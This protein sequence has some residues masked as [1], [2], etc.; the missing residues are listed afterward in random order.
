M[1][2]AMVR[3]N[4][5]DSGHTDYFYGAIGELRGAVD[6]LKNEVNEASKYALDASHGVASLSAQ[7][8][9]ISEQIKAL[10]EREKTGF[11]GT[12]RELILSTWY[13]K[14]IAATIWTALLIFLIVLFSQNFG[15]TSK[16]ID[17]TKAI[18]GFKDYGPQLPPGAR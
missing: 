7:V 9:G 1:S 14:A 15:N 2:A 6:S 10:V 5:S 12:Y 16:A 13:T 8:N 3:A 11:W 17:D 4:G 18:H